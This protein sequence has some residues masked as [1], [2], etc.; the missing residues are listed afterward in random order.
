MKAAPDQTPLIKNTVP[1]MSSSPLNV[2]EHRITLVPAIVQKQNSKIIQDV[3]GKL[4]KQEAEV[5]ASAT[6]HRDPRWISR[7]T[8]V[9]LLQ[10]RQRLLRLARRALAKDL[11]VAVALHRPVG[12]PQ[13]QGHDDEPD[14]PHDEEH[15]RADHDNGGKEAPVVD[16]P[17][18]AAAVEDPETADGREDADDARRGE[19][20][21]ED[22]KVE[23]PPRP[24]VRA[25]VANDPAVATQ[26]A[27]AQ[28][29]RRRHGDVRFRSSA[30]RIGLVPAQTSV[31]QATQDQGNALLSTKHLTVVTV[32]Y[33]ASCSVQQNPRRSAQ[34]AGRHVASDGA[35][36]TWTWT[37]GARDAC[38]PKAPPR[39]RL[40]VQA[41]VCR[42]CRTADSRLRAA[43]LGPH[44]LM[45]SVCRAFTTWLV[46]T[47]TPIL[48]GKS[49][50][51]AYFLCGGLALGTVAVLAA[52]MPEPRGQS[53]ETIQEAFHWPATRAAPTPQTPIVP[54]QDASAELASRSTTTGAGSVE[55]MDG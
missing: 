3:W 24:V 44:G 45:L 7:L 20:H 31:S 41:R 25:D 40:R 12:P 55:S 16:E 47:P 30:G 14:E 13:L 17:E 48:L 52:Y 34:C 32:E 36:G 35:G 6:A 51:G 4:S 11:Q 8:Y 28:H 18:Y 54:S 2:A 22:P 15:K 26:G 37:M 43:A 29:R 39:Q 21:D 38:T 1:G 23:L 10:P 27:G 53:L 50:F 33:L 5:T 9:A 46:V 42:A 19:Q 49:A